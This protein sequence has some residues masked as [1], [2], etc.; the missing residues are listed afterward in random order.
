MSSWSAVGDGWSVGVGVWAD[1]EG[2]RAERG[3]R[4]RRGGGA[5]ADTARR[6]GGCRRRAGA[7][8]M[9][10]RAAAGECPAPGVSGP[11]RRRSGSGRREIGRASCR[12]RGAG[13]GGD[14][15]GEE[16]GGSE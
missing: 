6:R 4:G 11:G 12:E 1:G 8:L 7:E 2:E 16:R 9:R 5:D 3:R 10:H 14:G 13:S 15:G